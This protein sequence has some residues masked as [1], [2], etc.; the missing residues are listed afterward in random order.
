MKK[1]MC[2]FLA[3]IVMVCISPMYA[4]ARGTGT[5]GGVHVRVGYHYGHRFHAWRAWPSWDYGFYWGGPLAA[6]WYSG[7][8]YSP[9]YYPYYYSAPP[10]VI[11]QQP[12]VYEE[13]QQP[14]SQYWYY[15]Q[16][17]KGYYPYVKT[18]PG[19]WMKVVPQVTPPNQPQGTPP[20]QS[21]NPPNQ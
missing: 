18:C 9:Y 15:C 11:Q 14:P 8:Y 20:D 5:H 16:D 4:A 1:I 7:P 13:R 21:P 12:P 10:A 6:P 17:P 3:V 2:G 19:G